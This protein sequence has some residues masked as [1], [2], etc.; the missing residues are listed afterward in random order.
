MIAYNIVTAICFALL[1][2]EV[3]YVIVSFCIKDRAARIA[4]LRSFKKGKC[5]F[6]YI[7][8]IP[9]YFIGNIYADTPK[10]IDSFFNAV[11]SIINLVV[12]KYDHNSI[13]ALMSAN[14]FY[15][16]TVY[17]LFILVAINAVLFTL[18]LTGQRV[19]QFAQA[20][21]ARFTRRDK[22]I[23][24]GFNQDNINIYNSDKTHNK[25]VVDKI[26]SQDCTAL[27]S[28]KINYVSSYNHSK[29]ICGI[30][31]EIVR[32]NKNYT[33]IINTL[34]DEKNLL[35][36][37][38]FIK[39]LSDCT[40][41]ERKNIFCRLRVYVFGDPQFEAVYG[42]IVTGAYGCIHYINKYQKVAMAFIDNYP[43]TKFMD[44][45]QI[46]Y[47]TSLL[48]E[49]I[50]VNVCMIGFGKTNRQIFL[51]SVANNQFLTSADGKVCLKPVNYFIFD[52]EK[53]ENNKNLN[54]N[55][56]RFKNE[57]AELEQKAYLPFPEFP[58][59]EEYC[60]LDINDCLFYNKIRQTVTSGEKDANF[61][62]IAFGTDLENIDMAQ[63][64][65]EKRREW[66]AK[67]TIFVKSRAL[68]KEQVFS[69]EENC[70]FIANENDEVFKL[71]EITGDSIF[72]MA[73]MR[74]EIYD[75][76][77]TITHDKAT[78]VD[79]KLIEE[80]RRAA[81]EKW[82][83][84]KSQL[85]RESSLYCCLSLKSK[86]HL[87][88]LDYCPASD[89]GT[90]LSEEEYLAIY[91]ADD[92]PD[93]TTYSQTADGKKIVNYTLDFARSRRTTMAIHEHQ[94]WNSF[95]ISKGLIP[96]SK[97]QI[98]NETTLKKG[99]IKHTNGKNYALR[100]HGNITTFDGLVE[101][102]KIITERDNSN[103]LENDVIKYDYQ[104]LDDAWWLL[105][106][107]GYKIIR[108]DDL[109]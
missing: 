14:I 80:N 49:G 39:Q 32:K 101:F 91:A 10:I 57:C 79:N 95:M 23:I 7:S 77:Y 71:S 107:N 89:G 55:Y 103:E 50:N 63:K 104:L 56:Y 27:Y 43:F 52:K 88:G 62:I 21:K 25:T 94:R 86:L 17:Y 67:F 24:F 69:E 42:E 93:T 8:A 97:E 68:R 36:C 12:L 85:E 19:W 66:N 99:K 102:R 70:Y 9:L 76:E 105:N 28:Q 58:A 100:R 35:L 82:Y 44:G 45:T 73:Q 65:V 31:K 46:D 6:V 4:F 64:L 83:C 5:A 72:H 109:I 29:Y 74:N 75:L 98:L 40:Q 20:V 3:V 16:I 26:S 2:A 48:K 22:L 106:E 30:F 90:A 11:G 15:E 38:D 51:T 41:E 13:N 78:V 92:K 53:A 81:N 33:V 47:D 37:R 96:S 18:S 1:T 54:H 60:R 84:E 59:R 61:V 34:S 87:M 108:K